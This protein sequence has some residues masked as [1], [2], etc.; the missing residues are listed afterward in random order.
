MPAQEGLS[1]A[2]ARLVTLVDAVGCAA[3]NS[4]VIQVL[5]IF[6]ALVGMAWLVGTWPVW[7][8]LTFTSFFYLIQRHEKERK[9]FDDAYLWTMRTLLDKRNELPN[10]SDLPSSGGETNTVQALVTLWWTSCAKDVFSDTLMPSVV[11]SLN[12]NIVTA[13]GM[14]D[15]FESGTVLVSADPPKVLSVANIRSSFNS[16]VGR[17]L[18]CS[19]LTSGQFIDMKW[20]YRGDVSLAVGVVVGGATVPLEIKDFRF[21]GTVSP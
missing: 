2:A 10:G 14:I 1:E 17:S 6:P 15:R 19:A 9:S 18:R 5:L 4:L 7:L 8:A 21:L 12:E 3:A 13:R 20:E 11:L 16:L